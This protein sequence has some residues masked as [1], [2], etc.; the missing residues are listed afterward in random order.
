MDLVLQTNIFFYITSAAVVVVTV[1]V[2]IVLYY[3]ARILR[4]VREVTDRVRRGSESLAEDFASLRAG[5]REDGMR[6]RDIAMFFATRAGVIP[7]SKASRSRKPRA[8]TPR[9]DVQ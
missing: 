5:I 7:G 3:V 8:E 4:D 6:L 1:L 2:C 9:E